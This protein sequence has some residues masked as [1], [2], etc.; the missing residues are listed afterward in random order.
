MAP[1]GISWSG[2]A[3]DGFTGLL[4]NRLMDASPDRAAGL[5]VQ[6]LASASGEAK[7]EFGQVLLNVG[8]PALPPLISLLDEMETDWQ[9]RVQVLDLMGK[10]SD[11]VA[12]PTMA[13]HLAHPNVWVR[14]AAA[15]ALSGIDTREV[16]PLL[17]AG[18]KD[19]ANTVVTASLIALGKTGDSRARE[20][21]STLLG[22]SDPRVRGAAVSALGRLGGPGVR[23]SLQDMLEDADEGVRYKAQKA[24]GALIR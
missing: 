17:V 6:M 12:L 13:E 8:K 4:L 23:E 3:R 10:L 21:S 20:A 1:G 24:L 14:I 2:T 9:T 7:L 5:A 16:V 15:H 22:H 18:L 19:S 11:S